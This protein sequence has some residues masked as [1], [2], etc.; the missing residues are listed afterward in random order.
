MDTR[1]DRQLEGLDDTEGEPLTPSE[2]RVMRLS[3]EGM[4][5]DAIEAEL[6]ITHRTLRGHLLRAWA[7]LAPGRGRAGAFFE[8]GRR[9]RDG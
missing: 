7:K 5:T 4:T 9:R 3:E 8:Y 2:E 1:R 6:H